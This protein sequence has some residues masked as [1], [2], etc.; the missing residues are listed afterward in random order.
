M[1]QIMPRVSII[2]TTYN[3]E[4]RI[5]KG[6]QRISEYIK[7]EFPRSEL[8]L[9]D[10]FSKDRTVEIAREVRRKFD[11]MKIHRNNCWLGRGKSIEEGIILSKNNIIVYL[12]IDNATDIQ[13][14]KS[15]VK[16]VEEGGDVITGSR[17]LKNSRTQR[18]VLR[19]C[20]SK[21]YNQLIKILFKSKINDHQCGFK[22]FNK[23]SIMK[24]LP[25][26]KNN[27]WFWDTELLVK[28]QREGLTVKEIPIKWTEKEDSKVKVFTDCADMMHKIFKLFIEMYVLKAN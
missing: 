24:V 28:S 20:L 25:K 4:N 27:H 13:Q 21:I 2:T 19:N 18:T 14:I 5:E 1:S 17:Y 15:L 11:I 12:D 9:V 23:K 26:V 7:K 3:E 10:D 16:R 22:A 6:L 8:I